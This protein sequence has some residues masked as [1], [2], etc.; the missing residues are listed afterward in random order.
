MIKLNS[1]ATMKV[2]STLMI[3]SFLLPLDV[4]SQKLKEET[5]LNNNDL[6]QLLYYTEKGLAADSLILNFQEEIRLKDSRYAILMYERNN[7]STVAAD[8]RVEVKK[9][10]GEK[11]SLIKVNNNNSEAWGDKQERLDKAVTKEVIK[12]KRN[13]WLAIGGTIVGGLVGFIIGK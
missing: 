5:E 7:C 3:A 10:K 11:E 9:L 13:R 8:A 1:S 12:T 4:F 2:L 6:R